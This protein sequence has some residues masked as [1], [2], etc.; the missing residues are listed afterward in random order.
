M[1]RALEASLCSV[2]MT[3]L[4]RGEYSVPSYISSVARCTHLLGVSTRRTGKA[5]CFLPVWTAL[6][7]RCVDMALCHSIGELRFSDRWSWIYKRC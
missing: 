4:L 3:L 7:W 1:V 6:G 2:Q 5:V